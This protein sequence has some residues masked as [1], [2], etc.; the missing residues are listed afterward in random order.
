MYPK[1]STETL[2]LWSTRFG[3]PPQYYGMDIEASR[4]FNSERTQEMYNKWLKGRP[5][6]TPAS[7]E[8]GVAAA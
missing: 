2:A 7:S 4:A 6:V 5:V 8:G 1:L 3:F